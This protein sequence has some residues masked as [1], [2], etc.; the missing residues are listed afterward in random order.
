MKG[1]AV[2]FKLGD[3]VRLRRTRSTDEWDVA[4][5]IYIEN[6]YSMQLLRVLTENLEM[7]TYFN[8]ELI[9]INRMTDVR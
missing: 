8:D 6:D 4:L 1:R 7:L 5:A 9:L 3:L 2:S